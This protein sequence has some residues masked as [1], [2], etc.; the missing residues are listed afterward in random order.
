MTAPTFDE[1]TTF[2]NHDNFKRKLP[3]EEELKLRI[4]Q[5]KRELHDDRITLKRLSVGAACVLFFSVIILFATWFVW[6]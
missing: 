3:S 2:P 6:Y 1:K 4:E 5:L